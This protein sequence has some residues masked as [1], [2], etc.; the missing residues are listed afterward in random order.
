M[1]KIPHAF[2]NI[3]RA[4]N[5]IQLHDRHSRVP[6]TILIPAR[7]VHISTLAISPYFNSVVV[8]EEESVIG[9]AS[10]SFDHL[11][12]LLSCQE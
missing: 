3:M 11:F 2:E 5:R 10:S 1:V 8:R 4:N 9:L 6:R 12:L 7:L